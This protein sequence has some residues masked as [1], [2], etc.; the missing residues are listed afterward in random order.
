MTRDYIQMRW[1]EIADSQSLGEKLFF[2]L[3]I[4]IA[5]FANFTLDSGIV[6]L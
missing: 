2:V 6:H 5:Q 1:N 3:Y 4:Y